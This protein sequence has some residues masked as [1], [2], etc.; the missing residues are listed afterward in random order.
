MA[1]G[2][3]LS[4]RLKRFVWWG[5]VK[6]QENRRAFFAN[7]CTVHGLRHAQSNVQRMRVR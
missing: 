4:V 3:T 7:M 2:I 1:M 6:M 5:D